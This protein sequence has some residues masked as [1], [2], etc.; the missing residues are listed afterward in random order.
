MWLSCMCKLHFTYMYVDL[1]V[2]IVATLIES[3]YVHFDDGN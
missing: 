2:D 3:Q 1:Y